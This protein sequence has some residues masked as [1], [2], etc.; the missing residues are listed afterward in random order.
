MSLAD[1]RDLFIV[2]FAIIGIGA[3]ILLV[4]LALLVFRRI[5]SILD[6]GR[7]TAANIRKIS[8]LASDGV[9]KPLRGI[10]SSLQGLRSALEFVSR[11]S[12]RKEGKSRERGK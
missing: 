6:S 10:A 8:S 9:A 5:R 12:G 11:V 1:L 7:Q 4:I 2:I 3:T